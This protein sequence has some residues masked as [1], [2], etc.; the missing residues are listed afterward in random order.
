MTKRM[1]NI[2]IINQNLSVG[3]VRVSALSFLFVIPLFSHL[4][5]DSN[6]LLLFIETDEILLTRCA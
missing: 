5:F 3:F 6:L 4:V 2:R 1:C